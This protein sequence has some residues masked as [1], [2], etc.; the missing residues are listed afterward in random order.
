[1]RCEYVYTYHFTREEYRVRLRELSYMRPWEAFI[2]VDNT[3]CTPI[4]SLSTDESLI[5]ITEY[6]AVSDIEYSPLAVDRFVQKRIDGIAIKWGST[7]N[8]L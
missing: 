6:R 8:T 3:S 1:M 4:W 5:I 7:L 2:I